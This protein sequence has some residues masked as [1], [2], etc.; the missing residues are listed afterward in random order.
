MEQRPDRQQA[1][2][3]AGPE[4]SNPKAGDTARSAAVLARESSE[5]DRGLSFYD[6]IYGFAIT[7]LVTNIDAPS[8]EAWQDPR[9]LL[10]S[11]VVHQLAGFAL[12]FAVIAVFWRMNLRLIKRLSAL[13]SATTT[14]N[15]LA[16][17]FVI[18]IPFTTQGVS[19]PETSSFELTT[20]LYAANII[21]ASMAQLLM[22]EIARRHGLEI[23]PMAPRH[24]AAFVLDFLVPPLV[25]A[26]SIP[27]ALAAGGTAGK[28]TWASLIVL[29]PV[30]GIL[31]ARVQQS[32]PGR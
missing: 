17:A 16:A 2:R 3:A 4:A 29:G 9:T 26:V 20:V 19:D 30:S 13:D 25:F 7:L 14:A 24:H 21:L 31:A 22:Y 10:E 32:P 6:V 11:G 12:S 1:A 15:L 23:D 8:A 27:V 5:F 28:I 18:L